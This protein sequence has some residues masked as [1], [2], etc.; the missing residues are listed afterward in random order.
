[1]IEPRNDNNL[2]EETVETTETADTTKA[3][4]A[5]EENELFQYDV[6]KKK[7]KE[8]KTNKDARLRHGFVRKFM[9]VFVL[10]GAAVVL[11]GVYFI[12]RHISPETNGDDDV[13]TITVVS[14]TATD[15]KSVSVNND[16]DSY[17]MYKKSGSVYKIEGYEDSPVEADVIS[18]SMGYLAAIESTKQIMVDNT[19]LKDFGLK[20]PVAEVTIT[21]SKETVVLCM[22][23]QSASGDYYFYVEGDEDTTA[24]QTAVYLMSETQ[25]NVCAA[26]HFYYYNTNLSQ[27]DSSSDLQNIT[28]VVIGGTKA[29]N[30]KVYMSD[31]DSGLSYV[32]NEPVNMPFSTSVMDEIFALL[33]AMNSATPV[34]DDVS[35]AA[36]EAV[37]L[38]EPSYELTWENN[39]NERTVLFG[40][41]D[42]EYIYCMEQNGKCIYVI[43]ADNVS[44]LSM[45]L[46]DMVDVITYTR[47]IETISRMVI[48]GN[49]KTYDVQIDN[50]GEERV[51]TVNNKTVENS[52]FS[53]FYAALLG[54]EIQRQAEKPQ[55]DPYV[56]I[57][58]YIS[59]ENEDG[60]TVESV[61]TLN[62]YYINERYCF[63]ELNGSGMFSVK[64]ADVDDILTNIQKVYDNVEI[65]TA[66]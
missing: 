57:T 65:V 46:A 8:K 18:T 38:D 66:W 50:S 24:E 33:T 26:D 3:S 4:A 60:E 28:P 55:G 59:E 44:V 51:V 20:D 40:D 7:V 1:M 45:D 2:N 17:K 64:S 29:T 63:Y 31:D 21:T 34:S 9:P 37:G 35:A 58:I 43:A 25:A 5:P 15:I 16:S 23:D 53:E 62:Y 11:T 42:G 49:Q 61:D 19:A 48:S 13:N 12:L 54:V 47:D 39:T 41:T 27:Y 22:G 10:L 30:I 56:T 6:P 14:L 52:I 36:L 32:I